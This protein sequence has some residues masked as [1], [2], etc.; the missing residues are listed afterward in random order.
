MAGVP[1]QLMAAV[2]ALALLGLLMAGRS[3]LSAARAGRLT[4]QRAELRSDV[5]ALQSALL[6]PVP[7]QI[8]DVLL[9]VAYRPAEGPAAGGDF[10]DV[11]PL[12]DG[13]L[14]LIVGDV[15]GH[16]RE[17]LAATALVHYTVRAYLAAGLEPRLAL[18]LTDQSLE[19]RLGD[20]FATVIVATYDP[21]SS[22]LEYATAGHPVPIVLGDL[23]DHAVE[24]LTPPPIGIGPCTGH[25]Q[26]SVSIPSGSRICLFTDGV[27]EARDED[28]ALLEREG[29]TRILDERGEGLDAEALLGR[30]I[31]QTTAGAD[32][33]TAFLLHPQAASGTG[34]ITEELEIGPASE[35]P[36]D[37]EAFL[38]RC[39]LDGQQVEDALAQAHLQALLGTTV[40]VRVTM[41]ASGARWEIAPMQADQ[42]P[43]LVDALETLPLPSS[44]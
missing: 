7:A 41:Q 32:D 10:H 26:T 44:S 18:R 20:D 14:G 33:M 30:V 23:Q 1:W 35:P 16:G 28:R 24:V 4:R 43:P 37:L 36:G 12:D 27:T 6:P 9:S 17:A 19:G 31:D 25:R 22:T 34:T 21:A 2:G 39:G 8:G 11:V 3:A 42:D 40:V 15:S 13:R 38:A 5:G 29:L